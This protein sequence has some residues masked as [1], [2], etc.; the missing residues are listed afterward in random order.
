MIKILT[1]ARFASVVVYASAA[2]LEAANAPGSASRHWTADNGNG[3]YSNPLFYEEFEDPDVIRVGDDYYFAGTTM[4]M[5][6][7][8]QIMRHHAHVAHQSP[9]IRHPAKHARPRHRHL[10][11]CQSRAEKRSG[12]QVEDRR[13]NGSRHS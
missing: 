13:V 6:P 4:H 7:A 2:T 9:L 1:I 10:A 5:N 11:W 8:V 12:V 3:T